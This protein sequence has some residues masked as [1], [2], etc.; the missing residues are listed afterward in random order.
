MFQKRLA[1]TWKW[2]LGAIALLAIAGAILL[3]PLGLLRGFAPAICPGAVLYAETETPAIAL[4]LDDGPSANPQVTASILDVL[5][6]HQAQATFFLIGD[7]L[8]DSDR[9]L[10]RLVPAGHEVGNHLSVDRPAVGLGPQAF[11]RDLVEAGRVLVEVAA[12]G[13]DTERLRWLR[14]GSGFCS[15]PQ[16]GIARDRGYRLALGSIW[17]LDTLPIPPALS[18]RMILARLHPGGILV[19]HDRGPADRRGQRTARILE[20]LLPQLQAR[21]YRVVTLSELET[22]GEWMPPED[23]A[24]P[25]WGDRLRGRAMFGFVIRKLSLQQG[26]V[27]LGL[28]IT[29]NGAILGLG[30]A[31]GFLRWQWLPGRLPMGVLLGTSARLLIFPALLEE[32]LFRGLFLPAAAEFDG[33]PSSIGLAIGGLGLLLYVLAHVPSGYVTDRLTGSKTNFFATFTRMDALACTTLLGLA[34]SLAYLYCGSLYPAIAE[35]W[36]VV[37]VWFFIC[38]GYYRLY[39]ATTSSSQSQ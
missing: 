31:T 34:C 2:V 23:N 9:E 8:P 1:S 27:L 16:H 38:G 15:A 32:W 33:R 36:L 21:G 6:A 37:W 30:F 12:G 19:L 25:V 7:R 22:L 26:R 4:T 24:W 13:G 5:A 10:A 11:E 29:I 20:R 35:H 14:P 39:P 28:F 3:Q 18:V 17:P